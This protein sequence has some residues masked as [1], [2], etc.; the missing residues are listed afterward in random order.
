VTV[1]APDEDVGQASNS[2]AI[3]PIALHHHPSHFIPELLPEF[4]L[5]LRNI[6]IDCLEVKE[7]ALSVVGLDGLQYLLLAV[8]G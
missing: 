7:L 8:G 2:V 5:V 4:T 1:L 6:L 3:C